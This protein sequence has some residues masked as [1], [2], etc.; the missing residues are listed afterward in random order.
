MQLLGAATAAPRRF[1]AC[2]A[3]VQVNGGS[4]RATKVS[5]HLG[6]L[7]SASDI[8]VVAS[9]PQGEASPAQSRLT[10]KTE[11]A[12]HSA[13]VVLGRAPIARRKVT[14]ISLLAEEYHA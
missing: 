1:V 10:H 7:L 6:A 3:G 4:V 13:E 11:G 14:A 12:K 8:K 5:G 2:E 9:L